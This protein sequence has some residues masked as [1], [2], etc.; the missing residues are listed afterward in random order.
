MKSIFRTKSISK[1]IEIAKDNPLKKTLGKF[2]L[3]FLGIGSIIGTGIFVL[4]GQAAAKYAGP[5]ISVSFLLSAIICI[6]AGLAYTELAS[7][8]PVAGSA[9][10]YS[11][12]IFGEI[13][14]WLVACGLILEYTVASST[15]AAGWSSYLVGILKQ[16]GVV[17]PE[18]FTKSPSEGGLINLPAS[19]IPL[20]VGLLLYRGTKESVIINRILVI[21]KLVIIFIFLLVAVPH[22]KI[23]N[24]QNFL[25]FGFEGVL[26]GSA[27]IFFAYLGFDALATTVEECKNPKTDLPV[28]I[29]GSLL[30]CSAIYIA[31]SL[32]LTGISHY[33]T[34]ENS[35]PLAQAL[36]DNGSNIGSALV[37]TGAVAGMI[38]VLLVM[39]YGQSRI[40]FVIS[41][42]GLIPDFFSKKHKKYNTPYVSCI[43]VAIS[44]SL[45]SGF[46]PIRT[47]GD[48][49]SLG[50]LFAL[51]V[52]S[53][54]V[55][56]MRIKKP[57][58]ERSFKCPAIFI[59]APIAI[60]GCS[61]LIYKL[62][63]DNYKCFFI[64]Y[65]IGI[66]FYFIYSYKKAKIKN[67]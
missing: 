10:T 15:V 7:M 11:Y 22:I 29:I 39:M 16:G 8:V 51:C 26:K 47:M 40:F 17:I 62:L 66:A 35:Q 30:I 6:F 60:I 41:R 36:R 64:F 27:A 57:N 20:F 3:I 54:G 1:I 53:I 59:S 12:V 46:T 56:V 63:L 45:I 25:P 65:T 4:T 49:S 55:I 58:L 21:L 9:Y 33:S 5:G 67:N 19:I 43:I 61:Y 37:G 31:V 38:T 18:H 24:Y 42:D 28:G 2:D 34:L 14:A 32:T 50:T 52:A 48:M 13:I 23:E 44:V